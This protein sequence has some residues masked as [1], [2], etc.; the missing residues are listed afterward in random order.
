MCCFVWFESCAREG[1]RLGVGEIPVQ[2]KRIHSALNVETCKDGW[3]KEA[4][5]GGK[6]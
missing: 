6:E 1:L 4:R 2:I 5:E 3:S